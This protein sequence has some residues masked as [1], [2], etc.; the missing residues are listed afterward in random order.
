MATFGKPEDLA[1]ATFATVTAGAT[2][3]LLYT[4]RRR[5]LAP[6][7]DFSN[8][9]KRLC[10]ASTASSAGRPRGSPSSPWIGEAKVKPP[11]REI[12]TFNRP[13]PDAR[14]SQA[15]ITVSPKLAIEGPSVGQPLIF[16]P[17]R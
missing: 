9:T 12:A 4:R 2:E 16:H 13:V 1:A 6:S 14:V 17:S 7:S 10:C 15:I 11:S 3:P 5:T 8:P